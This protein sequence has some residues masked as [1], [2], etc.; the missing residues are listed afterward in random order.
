VV[1]HGKKRLFNIFK[2]Y[3]IAPAETGTDEDVKPYL[4]LLSHLVKEEDYREAVDWY[5]MYSVAHPEVKCNWFIIHRG[6]SG[7]GKDL[8]LSSIAKILGAGEMYK[9]IGVDSLDSQFHDIFVGTTFLQLNE[10][11]LSP[12]LY[13]ASKRFTATEAGDIKMYNPKYQRPMLQRDY[14]NVY[15]TTEDFKAAKVEKDDRRPMA[16]DSPIKLSVAQA[17]EYINWRDNGGASH[18]FR[19][20]LN[21]DFSKYSP[22]TRP[23]RTVYFDAMLGNT[24]SDMEY[25]LLKWQDEGTHGFAFDFMSVDLLHDL[26]FK[27]NVDCGYS[28]LSTTK[29]WL[30]QNGY[31]AYNDVS[32]DAARP[33]KKINGRKQYKSRSYMIKNDSM[34][35]HHKKIRTVSEAYEAIEEVEHF[36]SSLLDGNVKRKY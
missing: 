2:G 6:I 32:G 29:L 14:I 20:A 18:L 28:G 13:S 7:A 26:L 23:Y 34:Y 10:G 17:N 4:D 11:K 25:T 1:I 24:R 33:A 30:L 27:E 36:M 22:N 15:F 21:Y 9:T 19:R 5:L 35:E 3:P 31:H 16:I 12:K 8:L